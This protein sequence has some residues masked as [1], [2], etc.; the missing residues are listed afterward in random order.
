MKGARLTENA[1]ASSLTR[2]GKV[3]GYHIKWTF[4]V[5]DCYITD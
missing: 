2:N 3:K 4:Y 1:T 5:P